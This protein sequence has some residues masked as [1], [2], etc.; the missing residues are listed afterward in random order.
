MSQQSRRARTVIVMRHGQ[1]DWNAAFRM[2]GRTDIPLNETGRA[3]AAAAAPQVADFKPTRIIAS[4]LQ[5]AFETAEAV[6]RLLGVDVEPAP[7]LM[8][9]HL[10]AWEGEV[11]ED[12][13][14]TDGENLKRWRSDDIDF[15]AGGTGE[16]KRQVAERAM[17]ELERVIPD[18][19]PGSVTLAVMHG[20]AARALIGALMGLRGEDWHRMEGLGNCAWSVLR[21]DLE[22]VERAELAKEGGAGV[23]DGADAASLAFDERPW[24]L[25]RHNMEAAPGV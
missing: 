11:Y 18:S 10:G 3:Q 25:V 23:S 8:E 13:E 21:E 1:T 17:A 12:V 20:G 5:R 2:Q 24:R 4:P 15:H 16:S 14:R 7:G 9:T 6:G 19:D 22:G